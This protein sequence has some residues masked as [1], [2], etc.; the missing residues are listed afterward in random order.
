MIG[1]GTSGSLI[2]RGKK[3]GLASLCE[4]GEVWFI[5]DG[6]IY[7]LKR[8]LRNI[9]RAGFGVKEFVG[10]FYVRIFKIRNGIKIC[11]R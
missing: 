11:L 10:G 8:W 9:S 6:W 1:L 5:T 3:I 7:G 2:D 4:E